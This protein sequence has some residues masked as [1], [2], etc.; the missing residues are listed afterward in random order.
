[1]RRHIY[2]NLCH[3]QR[4]FLDNCVSMKKL[5]LFA[6]LSIAS[7]PAFSDIRHNNDIDVK[8]HVDGDDVL[9]DVNFLVLASTR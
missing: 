1:M 3:T 9:V 2:T 6:F 7:L 5:F 8:V 4:S